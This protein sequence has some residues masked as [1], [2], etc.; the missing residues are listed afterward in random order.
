MSKEKT[1][2]L[3]KSR[4]CNGLQCPKMLW[5][6]DC[7]REAFDDGVMNERILA[8]GHKAGELAREYFN[9]DAVIPY[10]SD[11]SVMIA[12]TRAVM[13][14]GK[15]VIAEASFSHNNNFCSVDI[16]RVFSGYVEMIE[17]KSSTG[18]KPVFMD[19]MA[20]QYHVLSGA[21]LKVRKVSLMYINS[22]YT[23]TGELDLGRLFTIEDCTEAVIKMQKTTAENIERIKRSQL[24]EPV[25]DIGPRC[26]DPYECGFKGICWK[27]I[28]EHSVFDIARLRSG[29]KFELYREGI[30]SFENVLNCDVKLNDKQQRQLEAEVRELPPAVNRR[31]IRAFLDG[32]SYPLYFLDFETYMAAVPPF[33]GARPY[34]QI[35]FQYSLHILDKKGGSLSHREFLA[36]EGTDP[37]RLLAESLCKDIPLGVCTLAYNMS[38]EKGVITGLAA[39]FPDLSA[40]LMDIHDSIQDLMTPFQTHAYYRREFGGS[41]SIKAVLP[42]LYPNDPELDYS[43]LDTIHQ[44]SEAMNAFPNLHTRPPEEIA[45]IRKAL[46]AYCRLDT[47]AMVKIME[48]LETV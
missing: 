28:P 13:E 18:I 38:F 41:Y 27:H 22:A 44:G 29:K 46:L 43:S 25:E 14:Q 8:E 33:D 23:R 4:Y 9:A 11:K 2:F 30:V 7:R 1:I 32:L 15:A 5:L 34:M 16:L 35:P 26:D 10:D 40:R 42:A 20:F 19:D 45:Q 39:L 6:F 24:S 48:F 47:L 37:R 31:V 12:G 21:G 3:S 36:K 17:V